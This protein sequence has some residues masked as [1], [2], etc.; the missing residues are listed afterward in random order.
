MADDRGNTT[1]PLMAQ[2]SKL[3]SEPY[4][5]GFFSAIRLLDCIN[6]QKP[7]TGKSLRCSEES[8]RI[9][10][11]PSLIFAPATLAAFRQKKGTD[12]WQLLTYFFGLFGP[13]GPLPY[14]L[15]EYARDRSRQNR[16]STFSDFVDTFHHRMATMFYRAWAE[17]QPT[18]Q[19]DRPSSDRFA[20]FVGSLFGLGM[21]SLKNRDDLPDHAKLHF[22]AY[23]SAQPRHAD[24][25]G[26]MI[27]SFFGFATRI[28]ECVGHWIRLPEDCCMRLGESPDSCS[29]G[30]TTTIGTRVWDLQQK[31]RIEIGPLTLLDYQRFLPGGSGLKRMMALVRNY[32]GDELFWDLRVV[33]KKE[34]R[35]SLELGRRGQL[36]WTTWLG[37]Q[38]PSRDPDDL[39]LNSLDFAHGEGRRS[40]SA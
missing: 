36:G 21:D 20:A 31:F 30:Q 22:A 38:K 33:L 5:F 17:G 7:R 18:V 25:L 34:E 4:R 16:D 1:S 8:L 35:P 12:R 19:L 32:I 9:G 28:E 14:H 37:A 3:E 40:V 15:S 27:A 2:L 29:L 10:Q 39:I 23:L 26:A 11:E 24:G 6:D 13:N